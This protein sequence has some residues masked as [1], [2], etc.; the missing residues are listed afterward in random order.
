MNNNKNIKL[1]SSNTNTYNTLDNNKMETTTDIVNSYISQN[2]NANS[3][4]E[5]SQLVP[6]H[7][8]TMTVNLRDD[9]GNIIPT[10]VTLNF[11]FTSHNP[12]DAP[13]YAEFTKLD[14]NNN[15][16]YKTNFSFSGVEDMG[17]P[18]AAAILHGNRL[19]NLSSEEEYD[20][21][22][23]SEN[24]NNSNNIIQV[25]MQDIFKYTLT[26]SKS[27]NILRNTLN[28]FFLI[29]KFNSNMSFE[30]IFNYTIKTCSSIEGLG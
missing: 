28:E 25:N 12:N 1:S 16:I 24:E 26:H 20:N 6:A 23:N 10:T 27:K 18:I 3:N 17:L 8:H 14:N 21:N 22:S 11:F 9:D 13:I 30:D 15:T 4:I 7:T 29:N 5:N 2:E 19:P